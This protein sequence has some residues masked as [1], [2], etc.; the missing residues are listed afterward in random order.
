MAILL[1]RLRGIF[2]NLRHHRCEQH[3]DREMVLT[4][5]EFSLNTTD[6]LNSTQSP[7]TLCWPGTGGCNSFPSTSSH[8]GPTSYN[9]IITTAAN[10][11]YVVT[12]YYGSVTEWTMSANG[13]QSGLDPSP[14]MT[15][16]KFMQ[17]ASPTST[18]GASKDGVQCLLMALVF[19]GILAFVLYVEDV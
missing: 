13:T 18:S 6:F 10:G 19:L 12:G 9:H 14:T 15:I 2:S 1:C 16:T 11:A 5:I 4:R 7:D 3:V 8:G 17:N